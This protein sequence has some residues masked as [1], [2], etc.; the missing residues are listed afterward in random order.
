MK[1][2]NTNSNIAVEPSQHEEIPSFSIETEHVTDP[3]PPPSEAGSGP[4]ESVDGQLTSVYA[5]HDNEWYLGGVGLC[6]GL[7]GKVRP[8]HLSD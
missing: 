8:G 5:L 6:K 2:P 4:G 3:G 1:Q 7:L